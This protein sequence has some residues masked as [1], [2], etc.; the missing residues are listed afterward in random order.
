MVNGSMAKKRIKRTVESKSVDENEFLNDEDEDI[1]EGDIEDDNG[2]TYTKRY[3]VSILLPEKSCE[4]T[5]SY[6]DFYETNVLVDAK[7]E[8]EKSFKEDKLEVTIW[9][10][11]KWH[12]DPIRYIPEVKEVEDDKTVPP[13]GKRRTRTNKPDVDKSDGDRSTLPKPK[14]PRKKR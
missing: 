14:H 11:E 8:A 13:K 5:R 3:T 10:H 9:D 2:L 1:I 4:G 12:L 7:K 6:K